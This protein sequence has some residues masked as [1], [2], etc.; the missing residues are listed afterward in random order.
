M[1]KVFII[2]LIGA[3]AVVLIYFI[4]FQEGEVD[5]TAYEVK[6][7]IRQK[8]GMVMV[9]IPEGEFTMGSSFLESL[10]FTNFKLFV[11]PD[12][13]PKHKVYLDAFWLDQTEVTVGMFKKFVEATGYRTTAERQGWGKPWTKGPKEKEWPRT[14]G[15]D[16]LHPQGPESKAEAN[17]PV[18]QVSWEDAAAYCK[19]VGGQLP[20]EAQWEKAARGIDGRRYPWG[21]KFNGNFLNYGDSRCPVERWRDSKYDDGYAYTAPVGRYPQ[22]A[23]PYGALDMAGNVWEWVFDWY[24]ENYYEV[25]PYRNPTGPDSGS[26]RVLRGGSWYDGE[27][28]GWVNGLVRHQNPA[29]DR[30]EDVGFRCAMPD[31][32]PPSLPD[33]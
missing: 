6:T 27:P 4:L 28:K 21:N 20:T 8:D 5:N 14:P 24:D 29:T 33:F 16:W 15:T 9:Y 30:Y 31:D 18:I 3:A 11:F 2:L 26:V 23:S 22:G 12:Q 17:H 10:V 19:W 32:A 1:R 25:S 7:K 13:R